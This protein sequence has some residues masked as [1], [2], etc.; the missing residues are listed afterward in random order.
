M[1]STVPLIRL[2]QK[3]SDIKYVAGPASSQA[4]KEAMRT[5]NKRKQYNF[6]NTGTLIDNQPKDFKLYLASVL[7]INS[8]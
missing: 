2:L 3:Y 4:N 8:I 1:C 6:C 5:E 7:S